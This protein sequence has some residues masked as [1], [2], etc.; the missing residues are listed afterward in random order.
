MFHVE[1]SAEARSGV[2]CDL[3]NAHEPASERLD[4]RIFGFE[5]QR[6]GNVVDS[7]ISGT[8]DPLKVASARAVS[9]PMQKI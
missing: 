6:W 7:A 3:L 8:T 9:H 2:N 4:Q 1:H 5:S